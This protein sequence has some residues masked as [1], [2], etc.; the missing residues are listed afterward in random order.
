MRNTIMLD[1]L[2]KKDTYDSLVQYL[3]G[4]QERIK[5]PDRLAT[6]LRNSQEISNL[7]D[8]EGLSWL[9]GA[10]LQLNQLKAQEL[11]H[12]LIRQNLEPQRTFK[13]QIILEHGKQGR[14]RQPRETQRGEGGF[15]TPE[16]LPPN[17][18]T[19]YHDMVDTDIDE[20]MEQQQ[21]DIEEQY[22]FD[23]QQEIDKQKETAQ[24][25]SDDLGEHLPPYRANYPA[26]ARTFGGAGSSTDTPDPDKDPEATHEPR[27]KP[28][29][30]PRPKEPII[31]SVETIHEPKGKVGRPTKQPEPVIAPP[32]V[33]IS[34][35]ILVLN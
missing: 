5:Y 14:P 13:E 35:F 23:I 7:L 1:G 15:I 28:G 16:T 17:R 25:F 19:M 22:A 27:G 2:K 31:P 6:Q 8:N 11:A 4:G 30:P 26:V 12:L 18:Y 29:R 9:E 34:F 20:K 32:N 21:D 24:R 10:T 3:D 33:D